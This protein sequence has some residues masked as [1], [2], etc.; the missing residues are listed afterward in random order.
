MKQQI[1]PTCYFLTSH[2][3][4]LNENTIKPNKLKFELQL[5]QY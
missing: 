1:K 3:F 4:G 5:F 2:L